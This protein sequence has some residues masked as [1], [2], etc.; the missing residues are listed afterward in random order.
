MIPCLRRVHVAAKKK[1]RNKPGPEYRF[2]DELKRPDGGNACFVLCAPIDVDV[3][4]WA[5]VVAVEHMGIEIFEAHAEVIGESMFNTATKCI[6]KG[7][8]GEFS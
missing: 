2:G 7:I 4:S 3:A 8:G 1:G 6:A 5:G